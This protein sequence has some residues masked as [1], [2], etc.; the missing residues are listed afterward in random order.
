MRQF[1][2]DFL[3]TFEVFTVK[4]QMVSFYLNANA[5]DLKC[6]GT[7]ASLKEKGSLVSWN[8]SVAIS[9]SPHVCFILVLILIC[10]FLR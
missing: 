4:I 8:F 2:R 9:G 10:M 7:D 6:L 5:L 3:P 1:L